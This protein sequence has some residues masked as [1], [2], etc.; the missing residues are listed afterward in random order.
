MYCNSSNDFPKDRGIQMDSTSTADDRVPRG[1][2]QQ[3]PDGTIRISRLTET[4]SYLDTNKYSLNSQICPVETRKRIKFTATLVPNW[5]Y[6]YRERSLPSQEAADSFGHKI[7][8]SSRV[9]C[10]WG[11]VVMKTVHTVPTVLYYDILG[12]VGVLLGNKSRGGLLEIRWIIVPW[13]K[14]NRKF[15]HTSAVFIRDD[16][17]MTRRVPWKKIDL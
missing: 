10:S 1:R 9:L 4:K 13:K 12:T 2:L 17:R 11:K 3:P 7:V 6:A 16:R 14:N 15:V 8:P 5:K